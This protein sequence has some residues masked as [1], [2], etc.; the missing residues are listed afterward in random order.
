MATSY[1]K[2]PKSQK[3]VATV[4]THPMGS[5]RGITRFSPK[6]IENADIRQ[7]PNY[8]YGPNGELR[9]YN[10]TTKTDILLF[11][12]LPVSQKTPWLD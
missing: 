9:R 12:D 8:V 1:P 4:H 10:P 2:T 3:P 5:G 11:S 7:I 6:D